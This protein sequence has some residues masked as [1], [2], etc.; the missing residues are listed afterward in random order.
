MIASKFFQTFAIYTRMIDREIF[1]AVEAEAKKIHYA[2]CTRT[3]PAN[4]HKHWSFS[5]IFNRE[6]NQVACNYFFH[7]TLS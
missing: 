4:V 5:S 6:K 3:H 2:P 1:N 7:F